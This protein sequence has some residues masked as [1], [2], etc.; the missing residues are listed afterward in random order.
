MTS[1]V[2][3]LEVDEVKKW[4][5]EMRVSNVEIVDGL[6]F[7]AIHSPVFAAMFFGDFA[8]KNQEDI[9]LK[10]ISHEDFVAV[11]HLIYPSYRP[12][13]SGSV[14]SL[15][16]IADLYDIKYIFNK[17]EEYLLKVDGRWPFFSLDYEGKLLLADKYKLE[18]LKL[19][20][21]HK[22]ESIEE[23][24]DVMET[25]EYTKF[26]DATKAAML[27]RIKAIHDKM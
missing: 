16:A 10:D 2:I 9:E 21:L 20:C 6:P 5:G 12:I 18:A 19:Q 25:E 27:E 24:T 7:L 22:L 3:R 11:L 15:L 1:A 14:L 8:E 4:N 13:W 23:V 26:S 17:V